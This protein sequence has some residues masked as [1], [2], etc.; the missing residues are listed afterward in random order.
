MANFSITEFRLTIGLPTKAIISRRGAITG[1]ITLT[2]RLNQ[3][4]GIRE[5]I[6]RGGCRFQAKARSINFAPIAQLQSQALD[7]APTRIDNSMVRHTHISDMRADEVSVTLLSFYFVKLSVGGIFEL[8]GFLDHAFQP[9]RL[10]D[11]PKI[12][13][14]KPAVFQVLE[15]TSAPGSERD[16]E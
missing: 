9:A 13:L 3:H 15:S 14:G 16:D 7:N 5:C 4:K 10:V 12:C 2:T 8:P 11:I 6:T 1:I